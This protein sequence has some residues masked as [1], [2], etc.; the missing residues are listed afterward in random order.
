MAV[1]G[2]P[3]T[4]AILNR[5]DW[6]LGEAGRREHRFAWLREGPGGDW[7]PVDAYYPS[8][9]VVVIGS[10][11]PEVIELGER[12]VPANGLYLLTFAPGDLE[13]DPDVLIVGLRERLTAQ[14]WAPRVTAS[15]EGGAERAAS[16]AGHGLHRPAVDGPRETWAA[17][18][19]PAR[20]RRGDPAAG[21]VLVL[22]VVAEL[23]LGGG[24]IGLGAGDYVLGFGLLLDACA[25]VLGTVAASQSGDPAAAWS[26]VLLGS[27]VLWS[28]DDLRG[29]AGALAQVTAIVAGCAVALGLLLAVL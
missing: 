19:G 27:L 13:E 29:D 12:L 22:I 23:V 4:H 9:R 6:Q 18:R 21:V 11:A 10:D 26:R 3:H 25:R 1:S 24:V 8:N 28:G 20:P 15:P 17:R 14:G 7:L 5:L 16:R 2:D